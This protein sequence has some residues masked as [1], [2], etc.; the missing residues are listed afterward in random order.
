MQSLTQPTAL[1]KPFAENGDK[2]T[3]PVTNSDS[4]NPQL[5]DL[6][7]GFP[8][9]TS[10]EPA[11]GGLPAERKDFNALGYL[12]TL[13][14]YFYQAGGTFT[15][16]STIASAIGGYPLGARLWYTNSNGITMILRS[17]V[18]NN[19]YDFTQNQSY[20][21]TYW[22]ADTVTTD[23]FQTVDA[24]PANPVSGVYYFIRG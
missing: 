12:T 19:S 1:L 20:I 5:A 3:I 15:Y 6:T 17:T 18:A 7:N 16:N 13:Y 14:D 11:D 4:S 8:P 10:L 2:N 24:L 9:I 23:M 22:V 21:G